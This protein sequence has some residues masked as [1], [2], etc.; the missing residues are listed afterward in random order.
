MDGITIELIEKNKGILRQF[1]FLNNEIKDLKGRIKKLENSNKIY[2]N[3]A[4]LARMY[5]REGND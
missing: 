3:E 1:T 2:P 4:E 5:L